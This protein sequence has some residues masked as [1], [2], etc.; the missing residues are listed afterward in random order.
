M[1]AKE[2][3]PFVLAAGILLTAIFPAGCAEHRPLEPPPPSSTGRAAAT[4]AP[5]LAASA[6]DTADG[7]APESPSGK[8]ERDWVAAI[9]IERW[10]EAATKIDALPAAERARPEVRYARARAA[11]GAGD[12]AKARD[13]LTGLEEALPALASDVQR[14]RAEACAVA[15]PYAD[16]AASFARSARPRELARAA[17]AYER[18]GDLAAARKAAERAVTLAQ[19]GNS[20]PTEGAARAV[21]ARLAQG[22]PTGAAAQAESPVDRDV[23]PG[24]GRGARRARDAG[25]AQDRAHR[26]RGRGAHRGPPRRGARRRSREE[27]DGPAG[28]TLAAKVRLHLRAVALYK[29]RRHEDAAAA[30]EKAARSGTG[31]EAEELHFAARALAR[32]ERDEDAIKKHREVAKRFRATP[33]GNRSAF[34]AASSRKRESTRRPRR[35]SPRTSAPSRTASADAE[36]ERALAMLSGDNPRQA[37][38]RSSRSSRATPSATTRR[39]S[40]SS[41]ASRRCARGSAKSRSACGTRSSGRRRSRGHPRWRGRGSSR[42]GRRRHP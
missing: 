28:A 31:R 23:R 15:G 5:A 22:G 18:A 35:P 26:A 11:L 32:A 13:L 24:D 7:A 4:P 20:K 25:E 21:R 3:S 16:A 39:A 38:A 34:L 37:R 27:V 2:C 30:F 42:P 36:Y 10:A 40:S 19:K 1:Q 41:R 12:H 33:W 14:Y 6:T 9:R 17:E 29:A 8:P